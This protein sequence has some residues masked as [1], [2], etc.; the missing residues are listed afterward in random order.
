MLQEFLF[1]GSFREV[2]E[3]CHRRF[4]WL[5]VF[6]RLEGENRESCRVMTFDN[7]YYIIICIQCSVFTVLLLLEANLCIDI[8]DA[9]LTICVTDFVDCPP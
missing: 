1:V 2:R 4:H 6:E 7:I 5:G 3:F 9:L 8:V